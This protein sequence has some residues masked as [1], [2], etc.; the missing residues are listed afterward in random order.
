MGRAGMR[1]AV[2]AGLSLAAAVLT[3]GAASASAA[4]EPR[5]VGGE[6]VDI[7]SAPW[8]VAIAATPVGDD[9]PASER[10][11]CGG[12][13]LSADLVLTAAHCLYDDDV[14]EFAPADEIS[15]IAGRTQLDSADG[16]EVAVAEYRV[17]R[18]AGGSP[19][20]TTLS[21]NERWDLVVMRLAEEVPGTPIQIAGPGEA[22]LWSPGQ[23]VISTGWGATRAWGG[24]RPR[25]LKAASLVVFADQTCSRTYPNPGGFEP[26]DMMCASGIGTD[27][28]KGDSGGPVVAFGSGGEARLVGITSWG[29]DGWSSACAEIAGVY[30]R[31]ASDPLRAEIRSLA[32]GLG[33]PDVVGAGARAAQSPPPLTLEEALQLTRDSARDS[34]NADRDC[35]RFRALTCAQAGGGIRCRAVKRVIR[36]GKRVTCAWWVTWRGSSAGILSESGTRARCGRARSGARGPA[37]G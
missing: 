13:L 1:R 37:L 25:G 14:R 33:G 26:V 27:T 23:P 28:C 9:R 30:T 19:Y 4:S 22:E 35:R 7:S 5:I 3:A 29:G 32:Q 21:G 17:A 15:V 36:R 10:Q 20:Y 31:V 2:V 34:C 16:R 18:D 8:Q 11:F 12:S 24:V 6:R